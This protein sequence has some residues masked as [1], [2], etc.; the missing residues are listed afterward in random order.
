[1]GVI[2]GVSMCN[3]QN[4]AFECRR[5]TYDPPPELEPGGELLPGFVTVERVTVLALISC[6]GNAFAIPDPRFVVNVPGQCG[7][8]IVPGDGVGRPGV[9]WVIH[10]AARLEP[11]TLDEL[12]TKAA[13]AAKADYERH[14]G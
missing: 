10:S 5:V 6:P 4:Y 8:L 12:I 7:T 2:V 14:K 1:M 3:L 11:D 13:E 9:R